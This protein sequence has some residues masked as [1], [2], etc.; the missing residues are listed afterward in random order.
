M[1]HGRNIEII[2]PSGPLHALFLCGHEVHVENN[3]KKT[4]FPKTASPSLPDGPLAF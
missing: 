2:P 4:A 1:R 3:F